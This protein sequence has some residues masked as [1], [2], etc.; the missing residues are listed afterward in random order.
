MFKPQIRIIIDP[1]LKT[2]TIEASVTVPNGCYFAAGATLGVPSGHVIIPEA[3]GVILSIAK[4][5]GPCTEAIKVLNYRLERIPLTE[6]K[7]RVIAFAVVDDKV[8]GVNSHP[9][10]G[11]PGA[12][13]MAQGGA[14]PSGVQVL[15]VN[16]Y[17]NAMPPGPP[18]LIAI[19]NVWAPCMNFDFGFT[20][21]GPF[22]F[23]GKTLLV[24]MS[25][26]LPDGLC[27]KAIY[28]G[29]VPWEKQLQSDAEFDSIAIAFEGQL[30]FDPLEIVV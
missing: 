4:H 25:A 3:E 24:E 19:V 12:E 27:Q 13:Q 16:A 17:I 14:S 23:T 2:Y 6:G 5:D 29:P 21:R 30:Y 20:D 15:S 28:E 22:G 1:S 18:V 7:T 8:V 9:I 10:A 26:K 11:A